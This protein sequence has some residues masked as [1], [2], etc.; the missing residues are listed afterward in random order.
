MLPVFCLTSKDSLQI[1]LE[2]SLKICCF[3]ISLNICSRIASRMLKG[4]IKASFIEVIPGNA[5]PSEDTYN[6][7][8]KSKAL[9]EIH[10]DWKRCNKFS[11]KSMREFLKKT[12]V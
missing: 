9:L 3:F 5:T 12:M 1:T 10:E 6:Q 7:E 11:N 8:K 2:Q 4:N